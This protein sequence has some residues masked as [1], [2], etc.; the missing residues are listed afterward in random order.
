MVVGGTV[1]NSFDAVTGQTSG[2][3]R[4]DVISVD[5]SKADTVVISICIRDGTGTAWEGSTSVI[6]VTGTEVED[7]GKPTGAE[8]LVL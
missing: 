7:S 4:D 2:C 8:G 5:G 3:I 1:G 6:L